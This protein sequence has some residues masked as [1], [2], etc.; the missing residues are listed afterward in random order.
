MCSLKQHANTYSNAVTATTNAILND[1][2]K[3]FKNIIQQAYDMCDGDR[4]KS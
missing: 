1:T 3:Q 2:G 4:I